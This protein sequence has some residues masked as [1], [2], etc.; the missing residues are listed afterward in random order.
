MNRY[1]FRPEDRRRSGVDSLAQQPWADTRPAGLRS[2]GFAEDLHE[3]DAATGATPA[4]SAVAAVPLLGLALAG[5]MGAF[6]R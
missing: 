4:A 6:G 1:Q 5:V 3:P 2:E